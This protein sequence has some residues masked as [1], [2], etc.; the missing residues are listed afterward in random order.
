MVYLNRQFALFTLSFVFGTSLA[1]VGCG[2]DGLPAKTIDPGDTVDQG[3]PV[4]P[5]DPSTPVDPGDPSTSST[6]IRSRL[7]NFEPLPAIMAEVRPS[8]V[9][10]DLGRQLYFDPRLSVTND[11]SCNSCHMLDQYGVDDPSQPTSAGTGGQMGGRNAPTV[12]NAALHLFQF[13]DGRAQ[14]VEDQALGPILN[15][16]EMG[17]PDPETVINKIGPIYQS[18][19]E[20]AFCG[21]PNPM[22]YANIGTAIGAF[23]RTLV[24][25]APW[26]K[27]LTG[28]DDALTNEELAGLGKFLD[29][30][31]DSCHNGVAV[32]GRD[33]AQL[34]VASPAY[35]GLLL[36]TGRE[37]VTNNPFDMNV[38]KVPSLRNIEKTG[39]YFHNG[40]VE[41]I[42]EAVKLMAKY[43]LNKDLS[44][45]DVASIVTFLKAL[46][47]DL[48][49][50]TSAP[51]LPPDSP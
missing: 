46:T 19:F 8:Q 14:Q 6:T 10:I 5:G 48:P 35:P 12:Y 11:V 25:P 51:P 34:G 9:L 45:A 33:F 7:T 18:A 43:Q 36:D 32:G 17:M 27:Y 39:P 21:D 50:D 3:T 49:A 38:F 13:W 30:G 22:T 41:T 47:G 37:G 42:E 20:K 31:C 26:D 2:S 40:S 23:E 15:P 44:D 16:I 1:V 24:T 28:S 4:D 29:T